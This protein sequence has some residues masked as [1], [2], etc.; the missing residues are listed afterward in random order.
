MANT[1]FGLRL[2]GRIGGGEPEIR[3]YSVPSTD[4]TALYQ[5]DVVELVNT[6]DADGQVSTVKA[7][8]SGHILLG[9]VVG[10]KPDASLPY[11]GQYRAASTAR[12]VLVCDDAQ[13]IYEVIEDAI[14]G[15]V[16]AAAIGEMENANFI[17]AAGS[18]VTGLSGI[19]L[20][21]STAA[22]TANDLKIIGVRRDG[23]NAAAQTGGAILLVKLG[24]NASSL[25][26]NA[27]DSRT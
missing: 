10:F 15:A 4:G 13:A 26:L 18:T 24:S 27:D 12:K 22:A 2:V 3:E 20:D 19:M 1:G 14:G 6:M 25:A 16:S 7:A 5:G 8:T 11:T 21:S 23:V 17:V 9:V